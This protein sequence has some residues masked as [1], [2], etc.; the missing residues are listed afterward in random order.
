MRF[1]ARLIIAIVGLIGLIAAFVAYPYRYGSAPSYNVPTD[2][3]EISYPVTSSTLTG[4]GGSTATSA[5]TASTQ[6]RE[7]IYVIKRKG[8]TR[9]E[10]HHPGPNAAAEK[11]LKAYFGKEGLGP[12]HEI[13]GTKVRIVLDAEVIRAPTVP[14]WPHETVYIINADGTDYRRI[15][16]YYNKNKGEAASHADMKERFGDRLGPRHK[17]AGKK[18]RLVLGPW[19]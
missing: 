8:V 12:V 13:A 14:N 7:T 4:P 9:V 5:L 17:I 1:R 11:A 3:Q 2:A 19:G 16:W 6:P 18:V 15:D 10:H